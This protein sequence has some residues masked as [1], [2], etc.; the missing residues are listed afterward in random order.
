MNHTISNYLARNFSYCMPHFLTKSH[1]E[2]ESAKLC[3]MSQLQNQ[4][5]PVQ[6]R[7]N[8]AGDSSDRN[9]KPEEVI[10]KSLL[11]LSTSKSLL[12]EFLASA[13]R[14]KATCIGIY[15][16]KNSKESTRATHRG[17]RPQG[18]ISF[19]RQGLDLAF[20]SLNQFFLSVERSQALQP[21]HSAVLECREK[22]W[23]AG[24]VELAVSVFDSCMSAARG[25]VPGKRSISPVAL[26]A[27]LCILYTSAP[28][29][30]SILQPGLWSHLS[31]KQSISTPAVLWVL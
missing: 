13:S 1:Q 25:Q 3:W 14:N 23:I 22:L 18:T 5:H 6:R 15:P 28:I 2:R 24:E 21:L 17:K 31:G 7:I 9:I 26:F 29:N 10:Q 8:H 4:L 16:P 19:A 11:S 27:G 20:T 12:V 30:K